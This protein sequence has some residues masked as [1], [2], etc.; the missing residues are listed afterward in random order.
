MLADRHTSTERQAI[1]VASMLITGVVVYFTFAIV[2]YFNGFYALSAYE[3]ALWI[4]NIVCL[5]TSDE[6]L[7]I[8]IK[9]NIAVFSAFLLLLLLYFFGGLENTGIYWI[10][11][12]PL[13]VF[14]MVGI[15]Q[16]WLWLGAFVTGILLMHSVCVTVGYQ[17]PYTLVQTSQMLSTF[18]VFTVLAFIFEALRL[19]HYDELEL[20]NEALIETREQLR[21][22]L[23]MRE[24]EIERQTVELRNTNQRLRNEM[25]EHEETSK[26]LAIT[27]KEFYQSQKMESLGN[28][29]EQVSKTF[30]DVLS[31]V[32]SGLFFIQR[33]IKGN[34]AAQERLDSMEKTLFHASDITAQLLTFARKN[35]PDE[36]ITDLGKLAR[37]MMTLAPVALGEDIQLKIH[38]SEVAM[39]VR[40]S[41]SELQ[42][43]L[44]NL[45]S[46]AK[47]AIQDK[48]NKKIELSVFPLLEAEDLRKKH[49]VH[50]ESWLYINVSDDGVGIEPHLKSKIFEPFFTTKKNYEG[51]GLGLAMCYGAI[52]SL[53][54]LIEVE[55]QPGVGS[56]FHIYLPMNGFTEEDVDVVSHNMESVGKGETVLLLDDQEQLFR[57]YQR[58]MESMNYKLMWANTQEK[59][60]A[61]LKESVDVVV[62]DTSFAKGE[63]RALVQLIQEN[64][65]EVKVMFTT[66]HVVQDGESALESYRKLTKPFTV[67]QFCTAIREMLD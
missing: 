50:G 11:I 16:G 30:S 25:I 33:Q 55:S 51:T 28:L 19:Q 54:G 60:M 56:T 23:N 3:F 66:S 12:L 34:E 38:T 20:K 61:L 13:I 49:P 40:A 5:I 63:T 22:T 17:I 39:P 6:K 43:V 2:N 53:G 57:A 32:N 35:R 62:V 14:P 29:V 37:D 26:A 48:E 59:A 8:E 44:M 45:L 64:A 21:L 67:Q 18:A 46:N 9:G 15:R 31:E 58:V 24:S 52:N 27:E 41:A 36:N 65:P 1:L 10:P 42:Q 47:D 7:S 4:I